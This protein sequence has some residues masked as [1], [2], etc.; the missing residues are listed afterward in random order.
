ME[1]TKA[2][3]LNEL[4]D[5]GDL[6]H[7]GGVEFEEIVFKHVEKNAVGTIFEN[8]IKHTKDREFPDIIDDEYFGIEVKATKRDD[9]SSLGNSVLESSRGSSTQ[10]IYMF[11]G[12]LGGDPDI[13]YRDYEECLKGIAV[14]HYP[15]YQIDM[16]LPEGSSI[17]DKM[18]MTYDEIK[19]SKNPIVPIR[20]YYRSLLKEGDSLWWMDNNDRS[21]N[22]SPI[23]KSLGSLDE[24]HKNL[25]FAEI[26][27]R[28]PEI[29]GSSSKKFEKVAGFLVTNHNVISSNLRDAFTANGTV[30]LTYHAEEVIVPQIIYRMLKLANRIKVVLERTT[31]SD[32]ENMWQKGIDGY[33][34]ALEAWLN[35]IDLMST[36]MDLPISPSEL[37]QSNLTGELRFPK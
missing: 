4:L 19:S 33:P 1:Q 34:S 17:F 27:V 8:K 3:V 15:R 36:H 10:K 30:T 29:L 14:T 5:T 20:R 12:K 32:I 18:N 16:R 6:S 11:F 37:F 21:L 28:F 13:I 26:Y 35:E 31:V 25:L 23:L 9:W 2:T 22:S 24:D 7:V